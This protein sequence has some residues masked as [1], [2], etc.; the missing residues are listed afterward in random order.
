MCLVQIDTRS[1]KTTPK[2]LPWFQSQRICEGK[3]YFKLFLRLFKYFGLVYIWLNVLRNYN[4][5]ISCFHESWTY[6]FFHGIFFVLFFNKV[7]VIEKL[8]WKHV[9]NTLLLK[10]RFC[11]KSLLTKSIHTLVWCRV[12]ACILAYMYSNLLNQSTFKYTVH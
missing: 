2:C 4:V 5:L 1:M 8:L 6:D 7:D 12:H 11:K 9:M 3:M 10:Y